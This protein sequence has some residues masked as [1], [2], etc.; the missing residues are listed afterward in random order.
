MLW[1]IDVVF[2]NLY[3]RV[4]A[5]IKAQEYGCLNND[6]NSWHANLGV[7]NLKRPYPI[8]KE[9]WAFNGFWEREN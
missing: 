2:I 8:N 9:L 3:D 7:G 4:G 5:Y 1:D 6:S